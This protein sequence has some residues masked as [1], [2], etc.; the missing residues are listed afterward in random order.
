MTQPWE[1]YTQSEAS[2]PWEDFSGASK[3]DKIS[4][5]LVE[6]LLKP[7]GKAAV[8]VPATAIGGLGSSMVGGVAGLGA[9]A[10]QPIRNVLYGTKIDPLTA[11]NTEFERWAKKTQY[12][13]T[14]EEEKSLN[15]IMKVMRPVEMA[16]EGWA[17]L[18]EL[19]TTGDSQ[20]ATDVIVDLLEQL[21]FQKRLL[22]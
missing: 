18:T 22:L 8:R 5:G 12:I 17:G 4:E 15:Y 16:G 3:A 20:K 14:P 6:D 11:A 2:K 19:A 10:T 7:L 21:Q 1:D 9:A 13:Q